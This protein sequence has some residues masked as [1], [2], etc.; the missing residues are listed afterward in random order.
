MLL[1]LPPA[2]GDGFAALFRL[3][4]QVLVVKAPIVGEI[5]GGDHSWTRCRLARAL[6]LDSRREV[7]R[8]R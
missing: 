8:V 3:L 5:K 4:S 7:R 1:E 2:L 6:G